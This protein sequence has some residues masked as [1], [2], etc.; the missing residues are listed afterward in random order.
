MR[1]LRDFLN[2]YF[3]NTSFGIKEPKIFDV[4]PGELF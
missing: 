3:L 2:S 1:S 4:N